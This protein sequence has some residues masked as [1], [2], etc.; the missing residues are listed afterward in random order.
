MLP[1]QE[2][3]RRT[4]ITAVAILLASGFAAAAA[5]PTTR[6]SGVIEQADGPVLTIATREVVRR[7]S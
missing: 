7:C 5:E 6:V 4:A 3:R 1:S 2:T